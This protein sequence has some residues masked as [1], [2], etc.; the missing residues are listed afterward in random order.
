MKKILVIGDI[1]LDI[2]SYGSINRV[3]P[4]SHAPIFNLD[5]N[6]YMLGGAANVALN[7]RSLDVDVTLLGKVGNDTQ[8]YRIKKLLKERK[9]KFINL[10]ISQTMIKNRFVTNYGQILRLD[11]EKNTTNTKEDYTKI[12]KTLK[13]KFFDGVYI[14]DYNK[15]LIDLTLNKILN[16]KNLIVFCDPKNKNLDIFRGYKFMKPNKGYIQQFLKNNLNE[17]KSITD[18]RK[19]IKKYKISDLIITMG[20]E[21][22]LLIN[23]KTYL[24]KKAKKIKFYDL[25]GAGDTFGAI[26]FKQYLEGYKFDEILEFSNYGASKVIQKKGTSSISKDE[27]NLNISKIFHFK[28]EKKKI[29]ELIKNTNGKI[30]FTNGCFDILHAGHL[31]LLKFSKDQCDFLVCGINSDKSIKEIKGQNRPIVDEKKRSSLLMQLNLIDMLIIFDEK[32]PIK[33]IKLIKPKIIIKGSDYKKKQVVG[34]DYIKKYG[35]E[36]ILS[37]LINGYSTSKIIKDN[38]EKSSYTR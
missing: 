19:L 36:V 4:E 13:E 11:I 9:I 38:N 28:K 22:S 30:A 17:K 27:L 1:F 14:S 23:S 18:L 32:T 2:F 29:M 5:N 25:S 24:Y 26:F 16:K 35:G 7:L 34:S 10:K 3:S 37:K 12:N 21:G 20:S 6:Q 33:L 8:G 31:S 15:G